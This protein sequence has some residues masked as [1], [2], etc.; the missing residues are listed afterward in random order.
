[1]S[2]DAQADK[3][4]H[5]LSLIRDVCH[6][7]REEPIRGDLRFLV[8]LDTDDE[9]V[10]EMVVQLVDD[11]ARDHVADVSVD[12]EILDVTTAEQRFGARV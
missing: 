2:Y 12:V 8:V 7:S 4:E 11:Y 1:M 3:T 6:V 10:R 5:Q 9:D